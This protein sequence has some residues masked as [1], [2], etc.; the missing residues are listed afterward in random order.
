MDIFINVSI[1]AQVKE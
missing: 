1:R